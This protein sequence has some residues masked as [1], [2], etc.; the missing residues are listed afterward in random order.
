MTKTK[1]RSGIPDMPRI[2][3]DK[4]DRFLTETSAELHTWPIFLRPRLRI[5]GYDRFQPQWSPEQHGSVPG[6]SPS[7]VPTSHICP[8]LAAPHQCRSR[9]S[10]VC[11]LSLRGLRLAQP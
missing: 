5:A 8:D 6:K 2:S 9:S 3:R 4:L 7:N 1:A 10:R 11:R